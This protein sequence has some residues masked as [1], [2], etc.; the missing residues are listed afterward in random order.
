LSGRIDIAT[1]I[2][3]VGVTHAYASILVA[4]DDAVVRSVAVDELHAG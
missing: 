3:L 4:E 2:L 1:R